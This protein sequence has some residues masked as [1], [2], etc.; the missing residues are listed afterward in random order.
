MD[1]RRRDSWW[2][3][4]TAV[5]SPILIFLVLMIGPPEDRFASASQFEREFRLVYTLAMPEHAIERSNGDKNGTKTDQGDRP[6]GGGNRRPPGHGEDDGPP[7]RPDDPG[8][9]QRQG[10]PGGL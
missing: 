7:P 3:I 8:D 5:V 1:R 4:G 2:Q 9:P 10:Q 6:Q